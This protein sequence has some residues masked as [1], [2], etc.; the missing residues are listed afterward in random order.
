MLSHAVGPPSHP[1]CIVV[2][3]EGVARG[4]GCAGEAGLVL[5]RGMRDETFRTLS[6]STEAPRKRLTDSGFRDMRQERNRARA[7]KRFKCLSHSV[8]RTLLR[9]KQTHE[10]KLIG[11]F[12][13]SDHDHTLAIPGVVT[14]GDPVHC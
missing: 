5:A 9:D 1:N 14:P 2:L 13:E 8:S 4:P 6:V 10:F 12:H 7:K 3:E 11:D